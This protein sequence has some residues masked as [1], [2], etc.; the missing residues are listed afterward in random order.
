MR[1][2]E[3]IKDL[4]GKIETYGCRYAFRTPGSLEIIAGGGDSFYEGLHKIEGFAV[5]TFDGKI[6]TIPADN[7]LQL[8]LPTDFTIATCEPTPTDFCSDLSND[9]ERSLADPDYVESVERITSLL[10]RRGGKVVLARTIDIDKRIDVAT[11]FHNLCILYPSAFVF[12][13]SSDMFGTWIGASPEILLQREGMK[14]QTMSLAGT[15]PA[16]P[17]SWD[18]KN[19]LE[20]QMVTDFIREKFTKFGIKT[21]CGDLQTVSAGPVKHLRTMISGD[22][23]IN[24]DDE[25][26]ILNYS[27]T[28]ALCGSERDFALKCISSEEKFLRECYGGWCGPVWETGYSFYVNVR[29]AKL[30]EGDQPRLFSGG[31]ITELSDPQKEWK[32]TCRK[33]TTI[34]RAIK[35]KN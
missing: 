7:Q 4:F 15:L 28:P 34:L 13:F 1:E 21:F 27:P 12:Y 11:T 30:R 29:S 10:R 19:I 3:S 8:S 6:Y 33:A 23:P 18:V 32:E 24:F 35:L 9:I 14:V 16:G 17:Q 22:I 31:G 5:S 2:V 20:Q 26:F 25:Q